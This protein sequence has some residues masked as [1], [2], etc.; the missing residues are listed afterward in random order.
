MKRVVFV[1]AL[2]FAVSSIS[3]ACENESTDEII[4][5]N[6]IENEEVKESDI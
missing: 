4:D 2:A 5:Q 3:I 6:T 1:L